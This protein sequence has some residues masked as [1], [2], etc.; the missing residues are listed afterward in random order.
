MT[1]VFT[2]GVE[3]VGCTVGRWFGDW[4]YGRGADSFCHLVIKKVI[5]MAHSQYRVRDDSVTHCDLLGGCE[6]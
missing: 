1:E 3:G 4:Y 6:E 5:D 2:S